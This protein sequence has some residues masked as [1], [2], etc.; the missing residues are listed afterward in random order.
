MNILIS[1]KYQSKEYLKCFDSMSNSVLGSVGGE[2]RKTLFCPLEVHRLVG[3]QNQS[4]RSRRKQDHT[5]L[6]FTTAGAQRSRGGNVVC[7][8]GHRSFFEKVV[9]IWALNNK[10]NLGGGRGM[11]VTNRSLAE[12]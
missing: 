5:P 3:Q 10:E 6:L 1:L 12:C 7:L 4:V 11:G 2:E 9:L 8:G